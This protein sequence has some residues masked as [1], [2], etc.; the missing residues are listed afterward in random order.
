MTGFLFFGGVGGLGEEVEGN[1][2]NL[3]VLVLPP[4]ALSSN[5]LPDF[6]LFS[7]PPS[8]HPSFLV[9]II[10]CFSSLLPHATANVENT[11]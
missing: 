11:L 2:R 10:D 7:L 6:Y 9:S 5:L 1:S 4:A 3:D 8:F